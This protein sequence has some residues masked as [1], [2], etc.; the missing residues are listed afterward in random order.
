MSDGNPSLR[1]SPA[2]V[3]LIT[4][5]LPKTKQPDWPYDPPLEF[6]QEAGEVVFVPGGWH[7]AVLNI[8]MTVAVT[9]NFC[10]TTNFPVVW[11]RTL[12]GRPKFAQRWLRA[13][14]VREDRLTF[15]L[16]S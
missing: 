11:P 7:H 12:R 14:K 9:Q 1:Y 15:C 13:L 8:E 16:S 5:R 3:F 2:T 6:I 10:S 4:H